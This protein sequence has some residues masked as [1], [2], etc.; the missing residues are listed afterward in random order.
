MV[1]ETSVTAE[2]L[3]FEPRQ[4]YNPQELKVQYLIG[5][6]YEYGHGVEANIK[7]A[8]RW[9]REAARQGLPDA[10]NSLGFLYLL[11]LGVKPD[12]EMAAM[13]LHR[14]A[15]QGH[16]A[17][18]TNLGI[19]FTTGRGVEKDHEKAVELFSSAA[20]KGNAQAQGLL[21]QAYKEGWY[22]LNSDPVQ[23]DYWSRKASVPG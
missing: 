12:P 21:A 23:A 15:G 22:G 1:S 8:I 13:W 11:G 9:Y 4:T 3:P 18:Q 7:E 16:S 19:M 17:A 2:I 6:M 5:V 10:Q 20:R 14:A